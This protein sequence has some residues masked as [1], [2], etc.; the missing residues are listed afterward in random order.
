M[1]EIGYNLQELRSYL[2]TGWSLPPAA[3]GSWDAKRGSWSIR[4]LD[5]AEMDWDLVVKGK[6]AADVGRIEALRRAFDKL[7]RERLG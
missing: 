1:D 2:P 6:D 4:V 3:A 7:F 5:G